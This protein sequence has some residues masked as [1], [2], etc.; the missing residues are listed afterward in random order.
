[1]DRSPRR[2]VLTLAGLQAADGAFNAVGLYKLAQSTRGGRWARTWAKQDLDHLGF[3]ER[4][5]FVFPIIKGGSA[6]GL[7]VGVRWRALGRWTS[8]GLIAYYV[9]ALGFHLRAKDPLS[10]F[11]PAVAMLVWSGVALASLEPGTTG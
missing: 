1:M 7:V 5:R 9:A 2:V 3:P 11:V 10:K 8:V 6:A 4:L